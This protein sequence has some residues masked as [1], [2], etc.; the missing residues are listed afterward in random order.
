M[1]KTL[2]KG[3]IVNAAGAI[4][5]V[6]SVKPFTKSRPVIESEEL[7]PPAAYP[8]PLLGDQE[9]SEMEVMYY[10]NG[11]TDPLDT[12]FDSLALVTATV[13]LPDET[14]MGPTPCYVRSVDF[15]AI[16]KKGWVSKKAILVR[17]S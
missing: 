2:G 6:S 3:T 8:A 10:Y 15:E 9:V 16:T 1:A 7:D 14:A 5:F 13:T 4:V 17:A 11:G 12:A